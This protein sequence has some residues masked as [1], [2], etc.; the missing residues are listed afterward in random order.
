MFINDKDVITS[1]AFRQRTELDSLLMVI[2]FPATLAFNLSNQNLTLKINFLY[3]TETVL[4]KKQNMLT[5]VV[6][7]HCWA[8][9]LHHT[10]FT[11][12]PQSKRE[13]TMKRGSKVEIRTGRSVASCHHGQN[14]LIIGRLK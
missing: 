10:A 5:M 13:N 11:L 1:P 2:I 14:R 12:P 6:S 9:Q 4:S 3:S 7:H 8:A